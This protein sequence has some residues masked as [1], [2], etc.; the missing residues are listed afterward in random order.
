MR[1]PGLCPGMIYTSGVEEMKHAQLEVWLRD[2]ETEGVKYGGGIDRCCGGL[3]CSALRRTTS[4][5][6]ARWLR[7]ENSRLDSED[8]QRSFGQAPS[9]EVASQVR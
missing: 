3:N 6:S 8:I 4:P 2:L 9:L 7:V 5:S 1:V